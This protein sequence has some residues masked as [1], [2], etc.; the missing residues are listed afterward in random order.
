MRASI[1]HVDFKEIYPP[2]YDTSEIVSE[3]S[4]FTSNLSLLRKIS[5]FLEMSENVLESVESISPSWYLGYVDGILI[6][7]KIIF[8]NVNIIK[9]L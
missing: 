8:F 7:R 6:V 2:F 4:L 9:I 3:V 5:T 1:R